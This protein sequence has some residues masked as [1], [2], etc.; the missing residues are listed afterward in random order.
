MMAFILYTPTNLTCNAT[1]QQAMGDPL[2][3]NGYLYV[4]FLILV[5]LILIA[6]ISYFSKD[7]KENP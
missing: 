5:I 6:G 2:P 4:G 3:L 1:C 7:I